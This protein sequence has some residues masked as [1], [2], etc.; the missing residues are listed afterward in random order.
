LK[1]AKNFVTVIYQIDAGNWRLLSI[2]K[3]RSEKT[4]RLGFKA[5]GPAVVQGLRRVQ[6][7][8]EALSE[9]PYGARRTDYSCHLAEWEFRLWDSLCK[10]LFHLFW[11]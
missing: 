5:L 11:L 2:G 6:R 4:L 7:Y 1:K 10:W 9:C 3:R 8:V